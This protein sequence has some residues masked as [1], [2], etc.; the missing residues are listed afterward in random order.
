MNANIASVEQLRLM[1]VDDDSLVNE[2]ITEYLGRKGWVVSAFLNAED[3]LRALRQDPMGYDVLVTDISMPELNGMDFLRM[4]KEE[5]PY[6]PI[7]MITG[8]PSIDSAVLALK[9]GATDFFTKPFKVQELEVAIRKAVG[10]A[11]VLGSIDMGR[12]NEPAAQR[13]VAG[14]PVIA[15]RRLEEKIKELSILHTITETLDDTHAKE[16]IFRKTMDLAE[17][18]TDAETAFIMV[19]EQDTQEL[20]VI[21]A[22]GY[23]TDSVI[24]TRFALSEEPFNSVYRNKCYSYA[25]IDRAGLKG[26][27]RDQSGAG[28]RAPLLIMPMI[29]N[30]EAVMLM[31]LVLGVDNALVTSDGLML[32]LNLTAK[33]SLKL[34]NIALTENIFSSI[35]GAITSLINALDARDTYTKDHSNRVT[36]YA[37]KIALMMKCPQDVLDCI[38]F[39]GPLHDVGKIGIRDDILLKKGAFT[40]EERDEM[41]SHVL[42]G[43]EIL[44][45]LNLLDSEKAVVLYHHE[46]WDGKG[47]PNG[48]AGKEIPTPARIFCV[49]DTFDAMTS[50]RPYRSALTLDI[51]REEIIKCSGSQFDPEVVE[52]F[53][54]SDIMKGLR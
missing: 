1:L 12:T 45:P 13:L 23:D 30:R 51:A 46:R 49:A 28:E 44:R 42:R 36:Q 39:A 11:R 22:S 8:H 31:G 40:P 35:I 25:L 19:V 53:L 21:S 26:L 5:T 9:R 20:V 16:D 15:R 54:E 4:A 7:L 47:Y 48:I 37:V 27:G 33:A 32:L 18:I 3:A 34:E 14:M 2:A 6:I 17:I 38:S 41:K 43:E 10:E 24:G 29:I 50:S 52:A